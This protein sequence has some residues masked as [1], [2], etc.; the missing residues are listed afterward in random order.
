LF[1]FQANISIFIYYNAW[2]FSKTSKAVNPA[3]VANAST[4]TIVL[5]SFCSINTFFEV[6]VT[7]PN[8]FVAANKLMGGKTRI[9]L[10]SLIGMIAL[11][12]FVK[13]MA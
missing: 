2:S 6:T 4:F 13:P 3:L 7:F 11:E 1:A 10:F 9:V 12:Y 5:S 8:S